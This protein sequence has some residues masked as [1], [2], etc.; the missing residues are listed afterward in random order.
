MKPGPVL[1]RGNKDIFSSEL[2][3]EHHQKQVVGRQP[4]FGDG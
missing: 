1:I 2:V 4:V 3:N